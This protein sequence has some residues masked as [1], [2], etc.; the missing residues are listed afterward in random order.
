MRALR[1]LPALALCAALT[2][3]GCA[4]SALTDAPATTDAP[5]AS[6]A[7]GDVSINGPSRITSGCL[8]SYSVTGAS[9]GTWSLSGPG[10]AYLITS[11]SSSSAVV[12]TASGSSRFFSL[13]YSY[14]GGSA[15]KY[16]SIVSNPNYCYG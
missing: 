10:Q 5:A 9:G 15:T 13:S 14:S 3:A 8:A 16:V 7:P 4:D 6:A 1:F 11:P 2:L 12:Q